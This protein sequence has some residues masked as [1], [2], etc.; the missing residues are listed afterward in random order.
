LKSSW[1]VPDAYQIVK[2]KDLKIRVHVGEVFPVA[3]NPARLN[4]FKRFGLLNPR[5]ERSITDATVVEKS[6]EAVIVPNAETAH[7]VLLEVLA[8]SIELKAE[9]FNKYI[10]GEEFTEVIA[11]RVRTGKT[12]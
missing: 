4:R 12:A 1:I 2:G 8:N 7:V 6:L 9:D 10:Q 3:T 5:G 11:A